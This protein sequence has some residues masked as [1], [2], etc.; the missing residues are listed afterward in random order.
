MKNRK[1]RLKSQLNQMGMYSTHVSTGHEELDEYL[2]G[3]FPRGCITEFRGCTSRSIIQAIPSGNRKV[4]ISS[5][6]GSES[7]DLLEKL[8]EENEKDL[9][10][11]DSYPS[12]IETSFTLTELET[13]LALRL[14][15]FLALY[16][17]SF[18]ESET[19]LVFLNY[20]NN[21]DGNKATHA[22]SAIANLRFE[23][24]H[25]SKNK[26]RVHTIKK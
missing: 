26:I 21:Y 13:E 23:V 25:L 15:E 17:D 5:Q 10:V 1:E 4:V 19:A 9:I 14:A 18:P 8:L 24:K 20:L 2:G 16:N 12:A 22:L 11:F 7:V 3:G 6:D